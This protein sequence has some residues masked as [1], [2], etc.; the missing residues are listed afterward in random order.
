MIHRAASNLHAVNHDVMRAGADSLQFEERRVEAI[1]HEHVK[2]SERQCELHRYADVWF[3]A[4]QAVEAGIA[5]EIA[6]FTP[7]M[8]APLYTL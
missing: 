1:I 4:E 6:E 5:T 2:L 8:G 7:P 3:S